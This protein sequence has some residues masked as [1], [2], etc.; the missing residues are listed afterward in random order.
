EGLDGDGFAL[1]DGV[2]ARHAHEAG[3]AVDLGGAGAALSGLAVPAAGEVGGGF[4]LDLVAAVV[5]DHALGDAGV[6]VDE[7][8]AVLVAAPDAEGLRAAGAGSGLAGAGAGGARGGG[9]RGLR[10]GCHSRL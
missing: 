5:D 3:L 9:R 7:G 10:L 6:V 1:G 4:G 8:A 2:H